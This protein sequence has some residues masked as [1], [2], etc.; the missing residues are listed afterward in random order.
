MSCD[1]T[2]EG[3]SSCPV[4]VKRCSAGKALVL[5]CLVMLQQTSARLDLLDLRPPVTYG[6]G[7]RA[8]VILLKM[9]DT[10]HCTSRSIPIKPFEL[11]AEGNIYAEVLP[12]ETVAGL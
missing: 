1:T 12:P 9:T 7:A 8:P 6:K 11:R 2:I 10:I 4:S 3:S 5:T